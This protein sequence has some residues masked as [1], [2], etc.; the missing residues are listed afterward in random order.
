MKNKFSIFLVLFAS[1]CTSFGQYY[2]LYNLNSDESIDLY[3][4]REL[5]YASILINDNYY[6]YLNSITSSGYMW[7]SNEKYLMTSYGKIIQSE[8]FK[9]NKNLS[10]NQNLENIFFNFCKYTT[11]TSPVKLTGFIHFDNPRSGYLE[12][13]SILKPIKFET[14][15]SKLNNSL[16][17]TIL[18][19]EAVNIS[20]IGFSR[21]NYYWLNL[22]RCQ[23]MKSVQFI[24]PLDNSLI[25]HTYKYPKK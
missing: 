1:G 7:K 16:K 8:G 17:E 24:D 15:N 13:E 9:N 5:P 18:I 14:L 21:L 19:E 3:S 22:E 25:I 2:D 20:K 10:L 23:V 11:N 6:M 4:L 12:Y